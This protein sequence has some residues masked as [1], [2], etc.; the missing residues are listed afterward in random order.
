MAVFQ[1]WQAVGSRRWVIGSTAG[2]KAIGKE[3]IG[4]RGGSQSNGANVHGTFA[5]LRNSCGV[6]TIGELCRGAKRPSPVLAHR[7]FLGRVP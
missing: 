4:R 6:A 7:G 3:A 5:F 1:K 2:P